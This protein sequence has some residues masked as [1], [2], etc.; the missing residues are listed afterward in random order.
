MGRAHYR[1]WHTTAT[2]A[3][4]G[5]AGSC[6]FTLKARQ[7]ANSSCS[8]HLSHI[9]CRPSTSLQIRRNEQPIHAGHAAETGVMA[10]L[11]AK[12]GVT[13]ALDVLEGP[14]AG[15]EPQ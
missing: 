13:G 4:F 12:N 3:T 1:F 15:I 2:I 11:A 10:A 8:R 7:K 5:A 9:G 14:G 6:R